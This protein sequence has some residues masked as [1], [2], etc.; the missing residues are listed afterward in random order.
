[1][2]LPDDSGSSGGGG[3]RGVHGAK[4]FYFILRSEV[5]LESSGVRRRLQWMQFKEG[6]RH[7]NVMSQR[8]D[9]SNGATSLR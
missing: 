8:G 7:R 5:V 6:G 3:G 4:E 2:F 1:M 9:R